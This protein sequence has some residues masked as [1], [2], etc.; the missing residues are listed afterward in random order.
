MGFCADQRVLA[1]MLSDMVGIGGPPDALMAV[2]RPLT[3]AY[4]VIPSVDALSAF[5]TEEPR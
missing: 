1:A 5:G 2:T 4:Y 3:G